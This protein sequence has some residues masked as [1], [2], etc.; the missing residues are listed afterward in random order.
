MDLNGQKPKQIFSGTAWQAD[1]IKDMLMDN[2][3]EA[4]LGDEIWGTDALMD[5]APDRPGGVN[6]YVLEE[7]VEDA[8]IVVDRYYEE[9][10]SDDYQ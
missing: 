2:E 6:V 4:F 7:A 3:I 10:S 1:Q 5:H 9:S 8:K